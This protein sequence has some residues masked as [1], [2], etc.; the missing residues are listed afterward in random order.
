MTLHIPTPLIESR[1]LSLAADCTV[2]LKLEALQPCGSFKLRG[3]A[4]AC[5]FHHGRGAKRF[6]SSSGGNAGLAVAYVGRKLGLP[7]TVV[8]PETTTARAQQLLRLEDA[9]VIVH[10]Q[11]WQEANALALSLMGDD[12]A[13]IH[14]FDDPLLW[15]G[16]ASLVDEVA[17]AGIKPDAVVLSVGGGGLLSGVV[18]GLQRNGWADVPVL[19]VETQGAASLHAAI[20]AGEL[21][22]LERLDT[23]AT[24]LGAKQVAE[25]A[26]LCTQ[27]HPVQSLLVSD[28]QALEACERFLLDHRLLVEPACGA[29]LA[30]GYDAG[31]LASYRN[32]LVVVCGGATATLAQIQAWRAAL[33][34]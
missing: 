31:A 27:E 2:W 33:E 5:E 13:F 11:S 22:T 23:I 12:A 21:V 9:E 14:P 17:E 15:E 34:A 19:A 6:V 10:G 8:V 25:H 26:F 29:A 18:Q 28:R 4:H 32:V 1:P 16:H 30:V 7:V 20:E 24:T 3:V